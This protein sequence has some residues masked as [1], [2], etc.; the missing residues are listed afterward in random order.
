LHCAKVNARLQVHRLEGRSEFVQPEII[1]IQLRA[2]R[3]G[4][5]EMQ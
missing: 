4:L 5:A 1:W 2:L 3:Y